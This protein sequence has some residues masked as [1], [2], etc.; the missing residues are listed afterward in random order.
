MTETPAPAADMAD[1]APADGDTTAPAPETTDADPH[2]IPKARLDAEIGKRKHLEGEVTAARDALLATVP[3]KLRALAPKAGSVADLLAWIE[4][5]KGAGVLSGP[6]VPETD[7]GR[8]KTTPRDHDV[9]TLPAHARIAAG[10][11]KKG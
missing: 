1:P 4:A 3:E 2:M 9:S 11:A 10:Y 8:P 6:T 7:T 5:A